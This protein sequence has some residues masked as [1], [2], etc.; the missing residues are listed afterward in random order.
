M[1]LDNMKKFGC[2][3]TEEAFIGSLNLHENDYKIKRENIKNIEDIFYSKLDASYKID[4][5]KRDKL[6]R[7]KKINAKFLRNNDIL[8]QDYFKYYSMNCNFCDFDKLEED[9]DEEIEQE[10]RKRKRWNEQERESEEQNRKTRL[11]ICSG[12][13]NTCLYCHGNIKNSFPKYKEFRGEFIF[14]HNKCINDKYSCC[15]CHSKQGTEDCKNCCN[16]CQKNHTMRYCKCHY[17][18]KYFD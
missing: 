11:K 7:L 18:Q 8:H 15:I 4:T 3:F 17:C 10:K 9:L 13:Y 6:F 16:Y 5:T 1:T 14:A 12:C 2:F